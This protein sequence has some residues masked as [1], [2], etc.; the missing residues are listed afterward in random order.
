MTRVKI[1]GCM[2]VDDVLVAKDTGAD[3]VGIMFAPRSRRRVSIEDAQAIVD[4]VGPPLGAIEQESP[5]PLRHG[6]E[7][8]PATWY[9]H[10]A[11]ALERLLARKQPLTVGVFEDQPIEEVNTI[12]DETGLDLIQLSGSESWAT[13]LL[14]NRQVIKAFDRYSGDSI[15][16]GTAIACLLDTSR[17]R[18]IELDRAWAADVASRMPV[19][20]AGGLT[21][22]NVV[23]V[24]REVRPWAVDVSSGVE[25]DGVKDAEK[26]R[27]FVNA[28]REATSVIEGRR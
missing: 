1:C 13:C 7:G 27:A 5:P 10:G 4:A 25:T 28:A 22:E 2:T 17:G 23:E 15:V 19:W 3:F 21:P 12:A 16:S 8:D 26:I 6:V 24:L 20:L 11:D 18:G 9:G 14:A